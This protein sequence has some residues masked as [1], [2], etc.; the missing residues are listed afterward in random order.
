MPDRGKVIKRLENMLTAMDEN[1]MDSFLMIRTDIVEILKLLKKQ[2]T[3]ILTKQD[4]Y[5]RRD[6]AVFLELRDGSYYEWAYWYKDPKDGDIEFEWT[7]AE[8]ESWRCIVA[9]KSYG[10]TWRCWTH[11]P[12]DDET[13]GAKW[14]EV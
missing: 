2:A 12:T 10:V 4:I 9:L 6:E 14:D 7:H 3:T 11:R 13:E 5:E 8:G 1:H